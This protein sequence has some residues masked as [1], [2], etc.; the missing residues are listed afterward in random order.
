M[1]EQRFLRWSLLA[2][3]GLFGCLGLL[4]LAATREASAL[5][6]VA[7]TGPGD[8]I[9]LRAI[10]LRDIALAG[11]LALLTLYGSARAVLIV[12][13]VTLV[14]PAGDLVLVATAPGRGAI[15]MLLHLASGML[16][17]GLTIWVKTVARNPE[18]RRD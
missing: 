15:H 5:F 12:L 16:F 9:Y 8:H 18:T 13:V 2:A 10:G 6:G 1:I 17:A 7:G 14:I 4:F 3:S 11:Y